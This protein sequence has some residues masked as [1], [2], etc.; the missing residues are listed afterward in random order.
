MARLMSS[1]RLESCDVT[2]FYILFNHSSQCMG[3]ICVVTYR[4]PYNA[5][6]PHPAGEERSPRHARAQAA[7]AP[8]KASTSRHQ[9]E[10]AAADQDSAGAAGGRGEVR[11]K[12]S[13]K[14]EQRARRGERELK[15]S[16]QEE[17]Q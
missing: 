1:M 5:P 2:P 12:R 8:H 4:L 15:R 16:A 7:P 3:T 6:I 14:R 9:S 13:R 17:G 11:N 10:R